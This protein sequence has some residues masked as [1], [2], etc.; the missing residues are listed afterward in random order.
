MLMSDE[1]KMIRALNATINELRGQLRE[2]QSEIEA[3][4]I[5]VKML[6]DELQRL[7]KM[8]VTQR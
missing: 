4:T 7:R 6:D 1:Q 5:D 8:D 2:R 3:L